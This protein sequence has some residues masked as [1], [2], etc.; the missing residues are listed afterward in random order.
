LWMPLL[1]VQWW[2]NSTAAT[3]LPDEVCDL[4]CRRR[5]APAECH[6]AKTN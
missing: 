2:A 4:R 5:F 6:P 3:L 1:K